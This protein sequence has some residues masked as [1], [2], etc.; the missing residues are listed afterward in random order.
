MPLVSAREIWAF[1]Q[2][3]KKGWGEGA[4]ENVVLLSSPLLPTAHMPLKYDDA[5]SHK[6]KQNWVKNEGRI[7]K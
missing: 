2:S 5:K 7:N 6:Y 3:S 4:F 1:T